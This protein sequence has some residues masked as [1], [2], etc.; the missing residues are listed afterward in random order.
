MKILVRE[1]NKNDNR[2][3]YVWKQV[4]NEPHAVKSCQFKTIDGKIYLEN[5]VLKIVRDT[6]K[7]YNVCRNCGKL[8]K[9]GDEEKHYAEKERSINCFDC[10]FLCIESTGKYLKK[11]YVK[12]EDGTYMRTLKDS[13]NLFCNSAYYKRTIEEVQEKKSGNCPYFKCRNNGIIAY[14][15][16]KFMAYPKMYD[17]F[18]TEK[19]LIDNKFVLYSIDDDLY[20]RT[21]CHKKLKNLQAVVDDN[22]IVMK[23]RYYFRGMSYDFIY[24]K[25]Y[26]KFFGITYETYGDL[27]FHCQMNRT[28]KENILSLVK[29]IYSEDIKGG[30]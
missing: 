20:T 15:T 28:T 14:P 5:N 6:R 17:I 4:S 23:F 18:A 1:W 26:D 21:Y 29:N 11:K 30:K 7:L 27:S 2:L 22:G 10:R 16:T 24:A 19:S 9:P 3:E 13:V 12:Q 25:A 8:V